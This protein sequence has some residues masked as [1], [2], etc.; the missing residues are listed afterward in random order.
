MSTASGFMACVLLLVSVGMYFAPDGVKDRVRSTVTDSLRPGQMAVR[1]TAKSFRE[2]M[3]AWA[4][5]ST[6]SQTREIDQLHDQLRLEQSRQ[7][8]LQIQLAR[9]TDMQLREMSTPEPLRSLPRL[10]SSSLIDA[11]VLGEAVAESWRAG[12][13]LNRGDANGV[14]ESSLVVQSRHPL[15]DLGRDGEL[16]PEDAL[17]L[18]RCV[19]GKIER[20]GRWTSTFI[21]LTD[22][23]YRG[24]AQLVH[25]TESGFV[26]GA[27]G[28]L[29]GQGT[30][31]CRLEGIGTSD[32]VAIGDAVYTT[33]RDGLQGTPL[34]YG[35]V[36]EA[37]LGVDDKEWKV[38]VDPVPIPRDLDSVQVLRT[39]INTERLAAGS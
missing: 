16:S 21:L 22:S 1:Q 7:A 39:A 18:G 12:K 34:Y 5:K 32:A 15:V 4:T 14:R 23:E 10:T 33:N 20:V 26:F 9:L 37:T 28:I 19:I 30:S 38:L 27:K 11:A 29:K 13:L 25:Q 24:R 35:R 17:L 3:A 6:R 31:K 2:N 36:I 8:A